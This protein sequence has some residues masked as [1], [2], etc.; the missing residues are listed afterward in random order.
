[1]N[2]KFLFYAGVFVISVITILFLAAVKFPSLPIWP[3]HA[4]IGIILAILLYFGVVYIY[5]KDTEKL[6][7]KI[8]IQH[9]QLSTLINGIPFIICMKD[10]DGRIILVNSIFEQSVG[11]AN[12]DIINKNSSFFCKKEYLDVIEKEDAQVIKTKK[13]LIIDREIYLNG[14]TGWYRIMKYPVFDS[15]GNVIRLIVINRNIENEK[16]L[17][18]KKSTFIAT[19]THDLKTPTVSQIKALDILTKQFLGP[20][21]DKQLDLIE[22]VKSSCNYMSDLI[23]TILDT[24]LYDNGQVKI[25]NEEFN[26]SKLISEILREV[27]NLYME[28]RQNIII[29]SSL[30]NDMII[31]DKFQIKRVIINL[32]SN[33]I[34]Y[35]YS[36]SVININLYDNDSNIVVDVENKSQY[37]PKEKLY[38]VFEKFKTSSNAKFRKVGTGLGLYLSKQI[39]SAHKGEVHASSSEDNTCIFGFSI[40]RNNVN[41]SQP[42]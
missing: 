39:I 34:T 42:L 23:F 33:A 31:A 16:E 2:S 18:D 22:Q 11:L 10:L 7:S 14:V 9:S 25:I 26:I 5:L 38:D 32:L 20:L 19:L 8:L 4:L 17:E 24:Y 12:A 36:D 40:P 41:V 37:I 21:N 27:S 13:S 15:E 1:M 28:K 29:N 35:G 6:K 3:K 30:E